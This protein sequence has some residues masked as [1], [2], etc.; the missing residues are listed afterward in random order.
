M[1]TVKKIRALVGF[2]GAPDADVVT[3]GTAVQTKMTGNSNYPSPPVDLAILKT[4]IDS[5]SA[6]M[7]EA[8]DGS[9][10]VIAQKNKQRGTVVEMLR[11]LARYVEMACNNDMAIFQTSGFE[12]ASVTKASPEPLSEQIRRIDH[13]D[14]SGQLL[15]YVR[16]I[17][18][19]TS[20]ELR[21]APAVNGGT[22]TSWATEV[23]T[24]VKAP[25]I[26]T[27][28]TPATTYVFQARAL[29]KSGYTDW[30]DSVTFI[31]T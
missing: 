8:L 4:T 30:S 15:V 11:L 7:A 19:A 17:R 9:K 31:C 6:L 12:P 3:R 16:T 26:L 2:S 14:N 24:R 21:Y 25:V 23:V 20:Y 22:P 13:G 28:L 5:L 1:A 10:K 27:D 29:A 18:G